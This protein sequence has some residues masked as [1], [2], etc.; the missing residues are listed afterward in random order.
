MI[1]DQITAVTAAGNNAL[2][3]PLI[4]DHTLDQ[5]GCLGYIR[6]MALLIYY[7]DGIYFL[8]I[9]IIFYPIGLRIAVDIF[10]GTNF[11]N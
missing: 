1:F 7:Y 6:L 11:L 2:P 10:C 8:V 4:P 5:N 9:L 3:T